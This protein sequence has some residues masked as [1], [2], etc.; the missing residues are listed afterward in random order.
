MLKL[1]SKIIALFAVFALLTFSGTRV[2]AEAP[3][4]IGT[5]ISETGAFAVDAAYALKGMQLAVADANAHGGWLGRQIELKYYD[6]K[7]DAGTAVLLYTKLIT[8]DKVDLVVGPYSSGITQAVAPLVNK[9]KVATIDPEASLPDIFVSGNEWNFQGLASST[10]YLDDLLP[11]AKGRGAH[12]VAIVALKSAFSLGCYRARMAQA[13]ALGMPVVYDNTYALPQPDFSSLALAL[14]NAHP[15]V[16]IGC[17]Y[18]PDG[19]GITQALHQVGFAPK[20]FGITIAPA[21]EQFVKTLGPLANNILSNTS[22]WPSL[23]TKGSVAFLDGYRAK[24]R[25]DPDYHSAANYSA[26]QVLGA[27][28]AAT[29]SLDQSKIREWLLK[30]KVETIQGTFKVDQY[31]AETA[32]RQYMFQIQNGVSKLVSPKQQSQAA[33]AVPYTGS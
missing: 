18:Y 14:K 29:K 30:N 32:F 17:T 28:V 10:T 3:I 5:S 8:Q 4:V 21:E 24:F 26:I 31:G 13:K 9:Y 2:G 33:L 20:F 6:D 19:V 25:E 22:W 12:N 1:L 11:L 7:S 27:A 23:R 15:D 16:V